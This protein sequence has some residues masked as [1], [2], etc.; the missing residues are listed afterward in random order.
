MENIIIIQDIYE[1]FFSNSKQREAQDVKKLC[2]VA[3]N[4]QNKKIYIYI[5]H[6]NKKG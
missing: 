3:L 1:L 5:L 6:N 2:R 4:F